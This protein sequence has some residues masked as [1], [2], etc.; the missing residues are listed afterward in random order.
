MIKV[1]TNDGLE[2]AS[3]EALNGLGVE[4]SMNTL[5]KIYWGRN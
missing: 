2:N 4:V 5:T 1:L 3:I